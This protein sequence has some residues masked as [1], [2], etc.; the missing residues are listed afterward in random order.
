MGHSC[1]DSVCRWNKVASNVFF[2]GK[3]NGRIAAK[4][5]PTFPT[6]CGY[7]CQENAWMDGDAMLEWIENI[8]KL[9]IA[10]VPEN[11]VSLLLLAWCGS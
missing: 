2:I 9:F 6:G 11:V 1:S 4:E 3:Q 10:T 7:F 5:C 8:L